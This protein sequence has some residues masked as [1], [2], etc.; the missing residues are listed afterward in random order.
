V[1]GK[2]MKYRCELC[3][4]FGLRGGGETPAAYVLHMQRAHG[5][6]VSEPSAKQA[7]RAGPL[8]R[9]GRVADKKR[10]ARKALRRPVSRAFCK[11]R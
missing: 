4:R 2:A 3:A 8:Q 10:R 9:Q 7:S 5:V 1:E 11:V 6:A